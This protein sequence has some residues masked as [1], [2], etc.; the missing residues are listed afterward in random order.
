[1]S[2]KHIDAAQKDL[3]ITNTIPS[4]HPNE[5]ESN[6]AATFAVSPAPRLVLEYL[7]YFIIDCLFTSIVNT[8]SPQRILL[9]PTN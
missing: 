7:I 1:M 9:A 3:S 2:P 4:D 6:V 5:F 8:L